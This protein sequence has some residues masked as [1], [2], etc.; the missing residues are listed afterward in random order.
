MGRLAAEIVFWSA[1]ALSLYG[2]VGYSAAVG[3]LSRWRRR[4][5]ACDDIEPAVTLLIAAHDEAKVIA[6]KIE[7]CLALDY[8]PQ[9]LQVRIVSDGSSDGT[10]DIVH[11]YAGRGIELQRVEP[12]GGKP[13]AINRAL[14]YARGEILILCDANTMLAPGA[15][16]RLVRHFA[17][18]FVGAV[19]GD[20]RLQSQAVRYGQGEGLFWRM[21]RF[22]QRCESRIWST[23]GVDGGLYAIRRELYV[24]NRPDTL[25][26]DFVVAMNVAKAGKRVLLDAEALASEDS[27]VLAAQEFRRRVRTT[28]GGF[29]SLFE[30]RGRPRWNQPWL[31]AAYFSH[32]VL[33]WTSPFLLL[34][35]LA[36]G[37]VLALTQQGGWGAFYKV[38][39]GLAGAFL[40]LAAAG[41]AIRSSSLPGF[42]CLPYYFCLANAAATAG[43]FKWLFRAQRVTWAQADRSL[44]GGSPHEI[45]SESRSQD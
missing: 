18:P 25:I 4:R 31:W 19:S 38:V 40:V 24:R 33:K 1:N 21:E 8:P 44:P 27:V 29:Q 16:R 13:N 41:A 26:D 35:M 34:A 39:M 28:A 45:S 10:D 43:F 17:D 15:L 5:H 23:V 30:G 37:A 2:Y 42:V 7:N 9:K 12:R 11:R 32:K 20:V 3:L 36:A 6:A 14:P 22:T